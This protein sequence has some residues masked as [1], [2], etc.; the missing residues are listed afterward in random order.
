M[1]LD[2]KLLKKLTNVCRKAGIKTFKHEGLE[3]TLSDIEKPVRRSRTA[4]ASAQSTQQ[5]LEEVLT[6]GG[7]TE[8]QLMFFS[9]ADTGMENN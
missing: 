1:D 6:D 2:L 7:L 3:F 5:P 4:K 8:E 9:V